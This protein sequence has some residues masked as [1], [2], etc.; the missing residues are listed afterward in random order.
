MI[1]EADIFLMGV[2]FSHIPVNLDLPNRR[3][4]QQAGWMG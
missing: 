3:H 1:G 2:N 4:A